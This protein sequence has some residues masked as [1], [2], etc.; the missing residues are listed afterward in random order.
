MFVPLP[1]KPWRDHIIL[2]D[3]F[4]LADQLVD[5]V[6][7][8]E[9]LNGNSRSRSQSITWGILVIYEHEFGSIAGNWAVDQ[10]S[11]RKG[12]FR[13]CQGGWYCLDS[14]RPWWIVHQAFFMGPPMVLVIAA[15]I[16]FHSFLRFIIGPLSTQVLDFYQPVLVVWLLAS[17]VIVPS[18][19][20]IPK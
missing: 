8:W 13:R 14:H 19:F 9:F 2:C 12:I 15:W 10:R 11:W 18:W 6:A 16:V 4:L 7:V 17:V 5:I 1:G 20:R 3:D